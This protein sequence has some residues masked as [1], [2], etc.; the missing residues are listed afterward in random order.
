MYSYLDES[1]YTYDIENVYN[2]KYFLRSS[3]E[4][5]KELAML[6]YGAVVANYSEKAMK[7]FFTNGD[8]DN[9]LPYSKGYNDV[10]DPH[11]VAYTI[12]H[13]KVGNYDLIAVSILGFLYTTAWEGNFIVGDSGDHP[14]GF[15]LQQRLAD[16]CAADAEFAAQPLLGEFGAAGI[17]P[18][19]DLFHKRSLAFVIA[20]NHVFNEFM[21]HLT[22]QSHHWD[23][24]IC[25][26]KDRGI[27]CAPV[28]YN[29]AADTV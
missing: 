27:F 20:C 23:P 13:K 1:V 3:Y 24:F 12:A 22:V 17:G 4:Y 11:N 21:R 16:R 9:I 10:T 8:F 7:E 18:G 15:K 6:S 28:H 29:A 25:N 14:L 19:D 5:S 26:P 2:D